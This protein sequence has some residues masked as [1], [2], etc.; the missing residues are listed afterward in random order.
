MNIKRILYCLVSLLIFVGCTLDDL[1]EKENNSDVTEV[2]EDPEN[3]EDSEDSE[4]PEESDEPDNSDDTDDSDEPLEDINSVVLS[5]EII[6]T[7]YSVDYNTSSKSES[8]NTKDCVF[9]GD[10]DT[11]FASY[12]RSNTWVGL[13][14]GHKHVITKVG[15]A[16]RTSQPGRVELALIEGAN[17]ADFSD[18]LPLYIIKEAAQEYV[19]TYADIHCSRGFRYVRYV[20]PNDCRCNIAE[21]EFY[22]YKGDGDD[23]Q[24]YQLTNLPT[25]VINTEGG[26]DITS[27][28]TEINSRVYIISDNGTKL[29]EDES[30][31]VR[32]RGNASWGFPKKPYRLKFSEKRSPLNAPAKAKK[33]TLISNY[34]DKTLMRNI[35]AF[36]VS[37]RMGMAYTP[38]CHPVDL[39]LNGEYKGCYQLCDQIEVA[40]NRVDITKM[41]ATDVSGD[42]LTGGYLIEI[43]AYAYGESSMFTSNRGTPVTIKSPDDDKIVSEQSKYIKDFFNTMEA[44]VF[45]S[46]YTNENSGYRKYLDLD[47]FLRFFLVGEFAGNTDTYWSVYMYKDRNNGKLYTG[48]VWDYDL[49]FDNDNRTYP[50]NNLW[51]YIYNTNGSVASGS[52]RDM[53]TRVVT[54]DSAAHQRLI[55]IWDEAC[56]THGIDKTSLLEYVANTKTLLDESQQLN[57][58]RWKILNDYVHQNPQALGSYD[59]EVETVVNYIKGRLV[60]LDNLIKGQ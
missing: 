3:T 29:L 50:I 25:V 2:P 23:S 45:A 6:G 49:A 24:L 20:T 54:N 26:A 11:F 32:G 1:Y 48:P 42:N 18:A 8:V 57:F 31:G 22:G 13:D 5:G 51:S 56:A 7:R 15:Y 12:D 53:V 59:A 10:F 52:V 17:S 37:R 38:F 41:E 14:L 44:A 55:E 39:I 47:S 40:P 36:E 16:P 27:K 35:L 34:G 33:W 28:E 9:D 21:L 4:E 60:K 58:K 19:M 46:N 43:D 30:T